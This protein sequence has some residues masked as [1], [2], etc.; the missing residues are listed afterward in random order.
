MNGRRPTNRQYVAFHH[1]QLRA[2]RAVTRVF[3]T[4]IVFSSPRSSKPN[5]KRSRSKS[6][7]ACHYILQS[8]GIGMREKSF[9]GE[10]SH[11]R[12]EGVGRLMAGGI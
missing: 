7:S 3:G 8:C 10:G 9:A 6:G 4:L 2:T 5:T 11:C 12:R 1:C